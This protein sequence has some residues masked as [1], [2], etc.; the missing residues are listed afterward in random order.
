MEKEIHLHPSCF[1]IPIS[2][3]FTG[4]TFHM[5][6]LHSIVHYTNFYYSPSCRLLLAYPTVKFKKCLIC[7]RFQ[8]WGIF[9]DIMDIFKDGTEN[10]RDYR[11]LSS[12]YLLYRIALSLE[13]AIQTLLNYRYYN[14]H[15]LSRLWL[16]LIDSLTFLWNGILHNTTIKV[17]MD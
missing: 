4:N 3:S 15:G 11:P 1:M 7:L 5:P 6:W 13:Y 17:K 10:T 2:G 9:N 8:R 12:L 16:I 14:K